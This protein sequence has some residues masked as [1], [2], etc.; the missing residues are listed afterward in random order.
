MFTALQ[1]ECLGLSSHLLI[2]LNFCFYSVNRYL[3][4]VAQKYHIGLPS[5]VF[6][7]YVFLFKTGVCRFV[8]P[9]AIRCFKW[10]VVPCVLS[11]AQPGQG[12]GVPASKVTFF[13]MWNRVNSSVLQG[14]ALL[15]FILLCMSSVLSWF[16]FD[17]P[18]Q[19]TI[20]LT[21]TVALCPN[22]ASPLVKAFTKVRFCTTSSWSENKLLKEK[23]EPIKKHNTFFTSVCFYINETVTTCYYSEKQ[24][25]YNQIV[26][27]WEKTG[28]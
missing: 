4:F 16:I 24:Q 3:S 18:R 10:L 17:T 22:G 8:W 25:C 20:I 12:S 19:S 5:Q 1:S 23:T 11:A 26:F 14:F 15:F 28:E 9:S 6:V 7:I 21:A 13:P 27:F 2:K